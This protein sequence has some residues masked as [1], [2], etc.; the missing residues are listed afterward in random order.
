LGVRAVTDPAPGELEAKIV[1]PENAILPVFLVDTVKSTIKRTLGT[2]FFFS[3]KP[4]VLSCAHVLGILPAADEMIAVPSREPPDPEPGVVKRYQS[5]APIVNVRR[6][7]LHDIAVA[8]VP[9]VSHFEHLPLQRE[10]PAGVLNVMTYDLVSRVTFERLETGEMI[11][12]ITP[13]I[14]KGYV[15]AVLVER[16]PGMAAP[17]KILEISIPVVEGMSGAPLVNERRLAVAGVLFGNIA[18]ELAPAP[19]SVTEG[20]RWYLPVGQALHWSH[21][22]EFLGSIGEMR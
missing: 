17:A 3:A 4:I 19:R 5:M 1:N 20:A 16:E 7:P 18:R 11:R 15:H 12:T 6:H 10:D 9:G 21:V 2:A 8:D 22:Q 14:W 13:Y